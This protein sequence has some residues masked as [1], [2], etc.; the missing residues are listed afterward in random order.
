MAQLRRQSAKVFLFRFIAARERLPHL[1]SATSGVSLLMFGSGV[2]Y[3]RLAS[4]AFTSALA[5]FLSFMLLS[6]MF[7]VVLALTTTLLVLLYCC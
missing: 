3:H 2:L 5:L 1:H 7:G 4:S 6:L